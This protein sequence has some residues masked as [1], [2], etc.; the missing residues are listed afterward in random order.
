M[1]PPRVMIGVGSYDKQGGTNTFVR[2]LSSRL[3]SQGIYTLVMSH[4]LRGENYKS[5]CVKENLEVKYF[6]AFPRKRYF[7]PLYV[8]RF[9]VMALEVLY[10]SAKNKID[11]ILT[12]ETEALP[13]LVARILGTKVIIRGGNPF[14]DVVK[15]EFEGKKGSSNLMFKLID[16]YETVILFLANKIVIL[17]EWEVP[18]LKKY[19]KKPQTMIRYAVDTEKFFPS[20][21]KV[22]ANTLIYIGRISPSKNIGQLIS[23]FDKI[24]SKQK[25]KL[26]LIGQLEEYNSITQLTKCSKYK[27]DIIY[28]GEKKAEEIPSILRRNYLF[29]HVAHDLGNAPLEAA[30]SGLPVIVLGSKFQEKYIIN[31]INE[32]EYVSKVL[33]LLGDKK[34]REFISKFNRAYVLEN[35]S[36][37]SITKKY[38]SLFKETL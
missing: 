1:R 7:L 21:N 34:K 18:I 4:K 29:V 17:A 32:E 20:K 12:G 33:A 10:F 3:A 9:F 27:K 38:I 22:A 15:I 23:I 28:L 25:L 11:V 30:A 8:L 19:S 37:E 5:R 24:R 14:P 2:N 26:V 31:A 13:F 6:P 16:L 36:W 35:H